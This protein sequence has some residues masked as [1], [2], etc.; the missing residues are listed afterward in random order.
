[1]LRNAF[2]HPKITRWPERPRATDRSRSDSAPESQ[3]A[4]QIGLR[5][6]LLADDGKLLDQIRE[7]T[8]SGCSIMARKRLTSVSGTNRFRSSL[9]LERVTVSTGKPMRAL[10]T[11]K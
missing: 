9:E 6:T 7:G 3:T 5:G 1:M 10:P 4:H 2:E 8:G 11:P